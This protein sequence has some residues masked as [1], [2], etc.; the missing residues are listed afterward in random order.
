L[1]ERVIGEDE[2]RELFSGKP[3]DMTLI[4]TGRVLS[5]TIREYADEIY[6]IAPEK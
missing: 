3:D 4:C 5:D 2:I 6:R 1:D